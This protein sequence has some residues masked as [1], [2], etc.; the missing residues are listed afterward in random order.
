MDIHKYLAFETPFH[1]AKR[2]LMEETN[3]FTDINE[4]IFLEEQGGLY[5]DVPYTPSSL[6]GRSR[7]RRIIR[8]YPFVVHMSDKDVDR[9]EMRGTEHD[10]FLLQYEAKN[11]S[12][13]LLTQPRQNFNK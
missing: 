6:S 9:F 7:Q 3:L 11:S 12:T 4:N 1:A 5:L 10:D 13:K 2:E 8:V